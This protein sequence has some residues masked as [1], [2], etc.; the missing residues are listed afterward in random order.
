MIPLAQAVGRPL[1]EAMIMICITISFIISLILSHIKSPF[2]RKTINTSTG[3]LIST[4]TYGIGIFLLIPYNMVG[5]IFMTFA[6]R[7]KAH[8][9]TIIVTLSIL[10]FAHLLV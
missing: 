2:L 8:I 10:T 6:P 3:I 7:E 4:Y 5:F 1:D 9:Y